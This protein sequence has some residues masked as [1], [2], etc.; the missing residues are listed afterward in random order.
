[1]PVE[2]VVVDLDGGAGGE[3]NVLVIANETVLGEPLLERIRGRAGTGPTSFLI[4][5][6]QSDRPS[7]THPRPSA[8]CAAR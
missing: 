4:I 3:K 6:P 1:M 7:P 5:S 2:H 8:G